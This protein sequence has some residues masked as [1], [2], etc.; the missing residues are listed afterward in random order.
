MRLFRRS[1]EREDSIYIIILVN[2]SIHLSLVC[3][4]VPC[5]CIRPSICPSICPSVRPSIHP[6]IYP[7]IQHNNKVYSYDNNIS[8][9]ILNKITHFIKVERQRDLYKINY[10]YITDINKIL[11]LCQS[12]HTRNV[13][14][15][16]SYARRVTP[17]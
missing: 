11:T 13:G 9:G 4:S 1:M 8:E 10:H 2:P 14:V 5:L 6:S 15:Y 16:N 3:A 12:S 7:S 17:N